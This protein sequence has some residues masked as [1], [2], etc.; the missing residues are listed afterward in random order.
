MGVRDFGSLPSEARLWVFNTGEAI[1]PDMRERL[2]REVEN[3]LA[4]W[5]AHGADLSAGFRIVEDRFLLV[6]VDQDVTAPSGCSI[7]AM[8][9]FLRDLGREINFD[10]LDAPPC[11]YREG[12]E[13]RC[14][15]RQH[16]AELAESGEVTGSTT[17]FDLTVTSVGDVLEGRFERPLEGSW[18]ERAFPVATA[19]G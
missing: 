13:V 19:E 18:Y 9:R 3:F 2:Q 17:V 15:S 1:S 16:F 10:I 11:C 5:A 12:E 4:G 14:V 8:T 7:D 6:G